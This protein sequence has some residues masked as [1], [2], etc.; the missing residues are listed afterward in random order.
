MILRVACP[1]ANGAVVSD[2]TQ[3]SIATLKNSGLFD[4][5]QV[6][7]FKGAY[8]GKNRN[9]VIN[10]LWDGNEIVFNAD[11][12]K[13]QELSDYDYCLF[14]DADIEFAPED[15]IALMKHK[16]PIVSGAYLYRNNT[17]VFAGGMYYEGIQGLVHPDLFLSAEST[18]LNKVDWVPGGFMLAERQ[19]LQAMAAPWFRHGVVEWYQGGRALSVEMPEDVGFCTNARYHGFKVFMDCDTKVIHHIDQ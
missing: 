14:V 15:V 8:I 13:Y 1:I 5:V 19:V 11:N 4:E 6:G 2:A 9:Q 3:S 10:G 17:K 12:R 7:T 18:G 16:L